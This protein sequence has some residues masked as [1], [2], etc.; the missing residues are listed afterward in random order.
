MI[1]GVSTSRLLGTS[2]AIFTSLEGT[3]SL[4]RYLKSARL[5]S[6]QFRG[7]GTFHARQPTDS[8]FQ[9]EY[10]YIE[11][12]HFVTETGLKM[13]ANRKYIYRYNER[14]DEISVW[15][16]ED[17]DSLFH[18][19]EW[20]GGPTLFKAHGHHHC[21]K[22]EYQVEYNFEARNGQVKSF[23]ITFKVSGPSKSYTSETAFTPTIDKERSFPSERLSDV[24]VVP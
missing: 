14:D 18:K 7:S 23:R 12:G 13:Q 21:V 16:A 11:E 1:N 5:P 17:K 10:L 20:S 24:I 6:G 15:F 22:D 9:A 4:S 3:W 2:S 19:L 8:R